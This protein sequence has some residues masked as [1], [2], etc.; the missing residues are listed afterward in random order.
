MSDSAEFAE[1]VIQQDT[2]LVR[3]IEALEAIEATGLWVDQWRD[4][5]KG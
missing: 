4:D 5:A 1:R 3:A 2:V